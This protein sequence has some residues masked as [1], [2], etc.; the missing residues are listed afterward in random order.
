MKR[1]CT[2]ARSRMNKW[3][4][5]NFS[6]KIKQHMNILQPFEIFK[7]QSKRIDQFISERIFPANFWCLVL[8]AV[9]CI[10]EVLSILHS[11][12]AKTIGQEFSDTQYILVYHTAAVRA[13]HLTPNVHKY[14]SHLSPYWGAAVVVPRGKE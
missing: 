11:E 8:W 9:R 2:S 12:Y 4:T 5:I 6:L 10:Q 3:V 13:R 7:K 1:V 14:I